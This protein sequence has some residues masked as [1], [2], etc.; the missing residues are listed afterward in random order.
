MIHWNVDNNEDTWVNEGMSEVAAYLNGFGTSEFAASF[1]YAPDTQLDAW[2]ENGSNAPH[3]GAAFLFNAYFLDRFGQDA[4]RTLVQDPANGFQSFDKTLAGLNNGLTT[5]DLFN[6]WVIANLLNDPALSEGHYGYHNL[7]DLPSPA[8]RQPVEEYP[9]ALNGEAHQYGADYI[10]LT[11]PASLKLHFEGVTTVGYLPTRIDQ[12]DGPQG[13]VWWSGRADN[14]DMSLTR[15]VDLTGVQA[16]T[17]DFDLWYGIEE[18]WD[19][20]YVEVSPDGGRSWQILRTG[21]S[22]TSNP[23]G[24]AYGPGYSGQSASRPDAD[25]GGWLRQTAS[26]GL[27]AGKKILLRFELITDDAVNL[28]GMALDNICIH[29]IDWCDGAENEAPVWDAE[30]FVRINNLAPQKFSLQVVVPADDGSVSVMPLPLDEA[31]TGEVTVTV[32]ARPAT[33][34]IAGLTRYT[35]QTA[36]YRV[37]VSQAGP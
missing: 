33:L 26:L 7:R 37:E 35:T 22:T 29:E 25:A 11:G 6:D 34:V 10:Q 20:G 3:Y 23:H 5:D 2:E 19:Y 32:G 31:N 8:I 36:P 4:L 27:F 1:M 15:E 18:G 12:G 16:A 13:L 14:S 17:L 21:A 24:N 9:A 28:P 30:G